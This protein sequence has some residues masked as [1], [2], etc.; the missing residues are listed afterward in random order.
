MGFMDTIKRAFSGKSAQADKAVDKAADM[1]DDKTGGTYG[2]KIDQGADAAKDA[3][4]KLDDQAD[5]G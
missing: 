5:Q 3:V 1:A 4:H 2:D